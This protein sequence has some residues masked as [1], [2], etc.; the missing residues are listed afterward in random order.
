MGCAHICMTRMIQLCNI[1]LFNSHSLLADDLLIIIV[2]CLHRVLMTS[3]NDIGRIACIPSIMF[4]MQH[5]WPAIYTS[6]CMSKCCSF[7]VTRYRL[8]DTYQWEAAKFAQDCYK[9]SQKDLHVQIPFVRVFG[10]RKLVS[11]VLPTFLWVS[12]TMNHYHPIIS[13]TCA[14]NSNSV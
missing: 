6:C 14:I 5:K 2:S 11:F 4:V 13:T 3:Y 9:V 12:V 7:H 8:H 10:N 1:S